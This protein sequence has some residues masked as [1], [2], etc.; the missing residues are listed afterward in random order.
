VFRFCFLVNNCF[1]AVLLVCH[2]TLSIAV[3]S[4][5]KNQQDIF[6][7]LGNEV[8]M[9]KRLQIEFREDIVD[10][11]AQHSRWSLAALPELG[12]AFHEV[13]KEGWENGLPETASLGC[14]A[15]RGEEDSRRFKGEA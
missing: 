1:V 11:R 9:L 5:S 3:M 12:Q 7:A 14:D 4:I 8:K 13:V 15:Q 6:E 2:S 10:L